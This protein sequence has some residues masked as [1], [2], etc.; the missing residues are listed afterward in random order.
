MATIDLRIHSLA[1]LFDAMDPA[2]FHDKALDP[3]AEDWILSC[4]R[5][6]A[7]HEPV[8]LRVHGPAPLRDH[9]G[10]ITTA[11]HAHFQLLLEAADRHGRQR[12]RIGRDTLLI[13]L[14][15]LAA[16]LL[17]RS[18]VPAGDAAPVE[19]L[20]EGL[21]I[22]GWVALWL[23]VEILLF[24]RWES[25]QERQRLAAL[26]RAEVGFAEVGEA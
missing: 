21:L 24:E 19:A 4:A 16:C 1:Q 3:R 15:V 6:F 23:P 2:P 13:G 8:T 22:L 26:A 14:A 20:R 7:P 18:L 11:V 12:L 17:L 10:E 5:E 9:L 25:R